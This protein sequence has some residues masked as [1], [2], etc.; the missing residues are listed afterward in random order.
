VRKFLPF[1]VLLSVGF[2]QSPNQSTIHV[3][4]LPPET[5]PAGTCK[6]DLSGYVGIPK[7]GKEEN[8]LTDKQIGEYVRVRL[9]QGYSI[10]LYPQVSGK[11]FAIAKCESIKH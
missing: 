10:A 2:S 4:E 9:S 6:E 11:M 7:N 1:L 8:H 3:R 5:I